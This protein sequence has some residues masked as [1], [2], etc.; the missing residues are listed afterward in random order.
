MPVTKKAKTNEVREKM[1][2]YLPP[3]LANKLRHVAVDKR[4]KITTLLQ[5]YAEEGLARDA[6]GEK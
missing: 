2:L 6:A 5:K 1:S 4:L 3:A